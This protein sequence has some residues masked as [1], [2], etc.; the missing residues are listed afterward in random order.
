VFVAEGRVWL[1]V[2]TARGALLLDLATGDVLAHTP[3]VRI[4]AAAGHGLALTASWDID[5]DALVAH[6]LRA[7]ARRWI[8]SYDA[9][10]ALALAPGVVIAS[11]RAEPFRVER[12]AADTGATLGAVAPPE[13]IDGVVPACGVDYLLANRSGDVFAWPRDGGLTWRWTAPHRLTGVAATL[14]RLYVVCGRR[15]IVCLGPS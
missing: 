14:G 15:T 7:G 11:P 5:S 12:L 3:G 8:G 4:A 13:R 1:T 6:D 10:G 2:T 9:S